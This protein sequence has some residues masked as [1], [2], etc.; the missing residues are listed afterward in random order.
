MRCPYCAEEVPDNTIVCPYC[1]SDVRSAPGIPEPPPGTANPPSG[2]EASRMGEGALRF[3]HSG[4]R[5]L[6]GF[7]TDFFGI[8]D[9]QG[10]DH[11][12]ARFPR[13]DEGWRQAWL[14]FIQLEPH[15]AEI[16]LPQGPPAA[17]S[18]AAPRP[19]PVGG[20][21][22]TGARPVSGAWWLLPILFGTLG[23]IIAWALVRQRD[24]RAARNM[25]I[26]GIALSLVVLAIYVTSGPR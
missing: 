21:L 25:L 8:W 10:A 23:G 3:S 11:P 18:P 7:G 6:L 2:G 20:G 4:A 22:Q 1:R 19:P 5:Y 14:G 26:T 17:P 16:T 9:R 24:Q 15:P 13:T 12:I